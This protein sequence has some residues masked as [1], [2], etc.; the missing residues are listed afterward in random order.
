MDISNL[1]NLSVKEWIEILGE[2]PELEEKCDRF[3]DFSDF[4]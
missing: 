4:D 2:H 1:E 3:D